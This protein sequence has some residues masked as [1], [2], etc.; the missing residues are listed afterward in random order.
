MLYATW[1]YA[2]ATFGLAV[3][4]L[5]GL[6]V[7][8]WQLTG[9]TEYDAARRLLR[10]VYRLRDALA[11]VRSPFFSLTGSS[12]AVV[13]DSDPESIQRSHVDSCV[14]QHIRPVVAA[15]H[16]LCRRHADAEVYWDDELEA[17]RLRMYKECIGPFVYKGVLA[18]RAMY[19]DDEARSLLKRREERQERDE[20]SAIAHDT[21]GS[22]EKPDEFSLRVLE[23]IKAYRSHLGPRIR[24]RWWRSEWLLSLGRR[25][26][27]GGKQV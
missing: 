4:A 16:R 15:Y 5:I 22:R 26:R 23:V 3:A 18:L 2:I 6:R 17:L 13:D 12:A 11:E 21:T 20:A 27:A 1:L 8:S 10:A 25:F 14:S 24:Q 9:K 7:W 19:G